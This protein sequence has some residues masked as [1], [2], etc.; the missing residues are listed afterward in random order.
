VARADG[1]DRVTPLCPHGTTLTPSDDLPAKGWFPVSTL[2][3]RGRGSSPVAYQLVWSGK[4]V[5]ISG[6]VPI[7]VNQEA[8]VAL[9]DDF[10]KG[11]GDVSAYLETLGRFRDSKPDLWLPSVPT[12]GQNANLYD[13]DWER[14]LDDNRVGIEMNRHLLHPARP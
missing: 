8:G 4:T 12:D 11:R 1:L 2:P 14:T 5:L 6:T 9:F 10:L 7:K 3:M 13:H